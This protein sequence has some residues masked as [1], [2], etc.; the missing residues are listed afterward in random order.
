MTAPQPTA[1][2]ANRRFRR[3]LLGSLLTVVVGTGVMT[4]WMLRD[5]MPYFAERRSPLASVDEGEATRSAGHVSQA[6]R[7]TA[8]NGLS[9]ELLI[10]YPEPTAGNG[11]A[12]DAAAAGPM[13]A[14]PQEPD[15]KRPAFLILGGYRTGD[16]AATLV[17]DTH[18]VIVAALSY[19]YEG[20]LNPK[21]LDVLPLVPAI[22]RAI[23]DTPPAVLLALEYLRTR[24]DVDPQR[25]ELVGASFGAPFATI[26]AVLDSSV[27]R[28]W[29]VHAAGQPFTLIDHGL[30]KS[31]SFAPARWLV[32]GIANVL[33][34]GPRLTSEVWLPQVAPRPVIMIN[35]SDDE[36]LPRPAIEALHAAA[37][38]PKEVIWLPGLHVQSNRQ[39]VIRGLVETVLARAGQ[40]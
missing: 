26:A 18:G 30:K 38:E 15:A 33:A 35:A 22:R 10:R 31:I 6:V 14:A 24:P 27:S 12:L 34:A 39:D 32:A 4:A 23:F 16:R 2:P 17:E 25:I 1:R 11:P 7:L 29:L 13:L 28:L 20:P 40:P 3:V 5:P 19:P 21:G 9:A 8:A 37:R 36:R